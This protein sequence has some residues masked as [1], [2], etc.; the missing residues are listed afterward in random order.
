M[1]G[2]LL[3]VIKSL[4]EVFQKGLGMAFSL[5]LRSA[6]QIKVCQ[7]HSTTRQG[8]CKSC[9][10]LNCKKLDLAFFKEH[11]VCCSPYPKVNCRTICKY[12]AKDLRR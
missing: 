2:L 1:D 10:G 3:A 9:L 7:G 12:D 6:E 5:S 8:C 11:P 4:R